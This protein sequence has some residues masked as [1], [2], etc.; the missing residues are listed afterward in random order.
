MNI[1][2]FYERHFGFVWRSLWHLGVREPQLV[3]AVKEVFLLVHLQPERFEP[4][5]VEGRLFQASVRVA[6]RYVAQS[7]AISSNCAS[8]VRLRADVATALTRQANVDRLDWGLDHLEPAQRAV[9]I[10]FEIEKM[11][12]VEISDSLEIPLDVVRERLSVAHRVFNEAFREHAQGAS[13]A[14][15]PDCFRVFHGSASSRS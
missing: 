12:S 14:S 2:A 8:A 11:T 15:G 3:E 10:L 13:N 1:K 6:G 9:F 5:R 7:R 4:A